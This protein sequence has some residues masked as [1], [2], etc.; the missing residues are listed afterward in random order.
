MTDVSM[1]SAAM[2]FGY[3]L[4]AH[5]TGLHELISEAGGSGTGLTASIASRGRIIEEQKLRSS[6]RS[7]TGAERNRRHK[8][9]R[10]TVVNWYRSDQHAY[11]A[12]AVASPAPFHSRLVEF[13]ANHFTVSVRKGAVRGLA[14]PFV[15][16]AIQPHVMGRFEELLIAAELH[17][18]MVIYLDLMNSIGPNSALGRERGKGLNENLAREILELHTLGAA[19]GYTQGDV[20]EFAKMMTGWTVNRR[21]GEVHFQEDRVEP[22]GKHFIG[23][24]FGASGPGEGD[25]PAALRLLANHPSTARFVAAKLVTHFI[26]DTPPARAV[27]K[28]A[29]AFRNSGGSLPE[30]YRALLDLPEAQQPPG[31]KA[32][33][34]FEFVVAC[35]RVAGVG[36]ED[37]TPTEKA[38]GRTRP[39]ALSVGALADMQQR[40]WAAPSPAGWPE[41][42]EEWLGP[43]ALL[44]R[45]RWIARLTGKIRDRTAAGFLGRALGPLASEQTRKVV[46]AASNREEGLALVLASPEFNRR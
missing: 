45:L 42:A 33:T 2:R 20:T 30:V 1:A 34:D 39:N 44:Q 10:Q 16:E 40:L 21:R 23:K 22:G 8:L 15:F 38:G 9:H 29:A 41:E 26:A 4:P 37:M 18:A 24:E 36:P 32:R 7:A 5:F 31:A 27:D 43:V 46:L 19:G 6:A 14:G 11:V 13:W 3:G 25:Y 17:P 35:L 28:V 12:Q